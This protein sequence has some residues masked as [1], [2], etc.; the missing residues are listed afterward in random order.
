MWGG[1]FFNPKGYSKK[2]GVD[3]RTV[4]RMLANLERRGLIFKVDTR[5]WIN[6]NLVF[7]GGVRAYGEA[8]DKWNMLTK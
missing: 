1:L 4:M 3:I 8:I 6:P 2:V 7:N 5:I